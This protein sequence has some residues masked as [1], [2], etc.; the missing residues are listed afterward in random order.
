MLPAGDPVGADFF[1][2]CKP[3]GP[4]PVFSSLLNPSGALGTHGME[5]RGPR[6]G[7]KGKPGSVKELQNDQYF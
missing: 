3:P 7:K 5:N 2:P 6:P 1:I 4:G